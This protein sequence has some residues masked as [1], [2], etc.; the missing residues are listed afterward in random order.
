MMPKYWS[1]KKNAC[2]ECPLETM[3]D[4][5]DKKCEKPET[6]DLTVLQGT[7]WVTNDCNLTRIVEERVKILNINKTKQYYIMCPP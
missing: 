7:R 4:V 3:F 2:V 5:N 6:Y 1:I